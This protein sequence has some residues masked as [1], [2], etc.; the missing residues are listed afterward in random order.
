MS[1]LEDELTAADLLTIERCVQRERTYLTWRDYRDQT[2]VEIDW[3]IC[4]L[5][6][7]GGIGVIG[8]TP[9]AGKTWFLSLLAICAATGKPF[10]G[11]FTPPRP[12]KVHYLALEGSAAGI[13]HRIGCLARG[14]GIDPDGDQL[15]ENLAIDYKPPGVNLSD[16]DYADWYCS[17]VVAFNARLCLIDTAR[18]AAR[19]RESGEGVQDLQVL[20][21]N[22]QPLTS[23]GRSPVFAHHSRKA[24]QQS[25]SWSPP[26]ERLSGSGQLGGLVEV[27]IVLDRRNR[28]EWRDTRVEIDGRDIPAYAPM[29]IIS[30]KATA[31]APKDL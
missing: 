11:R 4:G 23:T 30:T 6:P 9:K 10:L 19:I 29:R 13:R 16:P 20:Q 8:S 27:G 3:L 7:A 22:L 5:I 12:I 26:L 17:E 2:P 31:R 21:A 14:L 24:Q 1:A 18:R 28:H 15:A 25:G